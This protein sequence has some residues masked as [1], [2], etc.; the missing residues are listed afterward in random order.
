MR[1][2]VPILTLALAGCGT[3]QYVEY[4]GTPTADCPSLGFH[5]FRRA[6]NGEL[7]SRYCALAKGRTADPAAPIDVLTN[8]PPLRDRLSV[9]VEIVR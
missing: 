9:P 5:T 1:H 7:D 8:Y 6:D 4:S 2:Y 3:V